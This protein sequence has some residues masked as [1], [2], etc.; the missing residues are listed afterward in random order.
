MPGQTSESP[1]AVRR[2]VEITIELAPDCGRGINYMTT[3]GA[4]A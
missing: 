2:A 1:L 4:R 3:P